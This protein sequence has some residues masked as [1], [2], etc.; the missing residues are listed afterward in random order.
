[1]LKEQDHPNPYIY[2]RGVSYYDLSAILDFVY[3]GEVSVAQEDLNSFLAV[4]EELKIKGL[5]NNRNKVQVRPFF[6]C[7]K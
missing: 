4:A 1:M 2:L 5:T 6:W 3:H 7:Q